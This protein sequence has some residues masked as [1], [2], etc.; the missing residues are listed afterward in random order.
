REHSHRRAPGPAAENRWPFS[1]PW[2]SLLSPMAQKI[3]S[4][5]RREEGSDCR[6]NRIEGARARHP[7]NLGGGGGYG[8]RVG[9]ALLATIAHHKRRVVDRGSTQIAETKFSS[10]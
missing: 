9:G 6:R 8:S 10:R 5:S 3:D 4:N 1:V 7:C 2:M